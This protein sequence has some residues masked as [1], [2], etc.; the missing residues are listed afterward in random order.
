MG[1]KS[2]AYTPQNPINE[3]RSQQNGL[4]IKAEDLEPGDGVIVEPILS[5]KIYSEEKLDLNQISDKTE[6]PKKEI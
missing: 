1:D 5:H 2:D 3:D 4:S 6:C